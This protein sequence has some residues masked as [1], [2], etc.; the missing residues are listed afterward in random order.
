M[1]SAAVLGSSDSLKPE[2]QTRIRGARERFWKETRLNKENM[3]AMQ[4]V[5]DWDEDLRRCT[6]ERVLLGFLSE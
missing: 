1:H 6:V 4:E 5:L 3:L 2:G